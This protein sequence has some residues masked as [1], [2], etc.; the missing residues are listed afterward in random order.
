MTDYA[1]AQPDDDQPQHQD[2]FTADAEVSLSEIR[3]AGK[4]GVG[5]RLD[6]TNPQAINKEV[7]L[8][9]ARKI[10]PERIANKINELLDMTRTLKDGSEIPDVRAREAGV[11]L[12]LAYMVGLPT[13]RQEIISVSVDADSS[14][15]LKD[16]L[17]ASPALRAALR[18]SLDDAD[19]K[20]GPVVEG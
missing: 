14:A 12:A 5:K 3:A 11:K 13:Q 4:R 19:S 15:G 2:E 8:A 17:A 16:R 18:R 9:I 1:P 7:V 20:A 6:L 10:S